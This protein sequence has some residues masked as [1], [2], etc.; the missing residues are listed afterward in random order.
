VTFPVSIRVGPLDVPAHGI[1]EAIAYAA[2]FRVFL[3]ESRRA[4]AASAPPSGIPLLWLLLGCVAGAA[5]GA[6]LLAVLEHLPAGG[7]DPGGKTIVGGLLGGWAGVEV[8]KARL[9]LRAATGDAFV[10]P[11]GVGIFLGRVG[12]FLDGLRDG[13]QGSPTSLPL[14][15]D[16]GDG[17][18]RHPA[19]LYDG[20]AALAFG[21]AL[22][23]LP[24]AALPAGG[25]FRLFVAA[26]LG[27]RFLLD[28]LKPVEAFALG[29]GAIQ[30]ACLAGAAAALVSLRRLPREAPARG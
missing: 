12:C 21:V 9:G 10:L 5:I 3:R 13:T 23:R 17:V 7:A 15:V 4:P 11:L 8:A 18:P 20:V 1:L 27:S 26:Y 30:V 29:L 25:R 24:L 6:R 14:G 28:F 2:G 19:S 22:A 16:F